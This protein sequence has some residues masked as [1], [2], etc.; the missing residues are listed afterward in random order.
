MGI[1]DRVDRRC[2]RRHDAPQYPSQDRTLFVDLE[3]RETRRKSLPVAVLRTFI[4]GGA[5]RGAF[6]LKGAI[7]LGKASADEF[8]AEPKARNKAI[9]K[10]IT[11]ASA[12]TSALKISGHAAPVQA[13]TGAGRDGRHEQPG[14]DLG[15]DARRGQLRSV[16]PGH[17]RMLQVPRPARARHRRRSS[18]PASSHAPG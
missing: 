3:R 10:K 8:S 14:D 13:V 5:K 7:V 17:G 18:V 12:I 16:P 6:R 11:G 1:R 9:G 15:R 2:A 4:G